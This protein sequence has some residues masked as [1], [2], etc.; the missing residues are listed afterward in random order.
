ML[1]SRRPRAGC[2]AWSS[3]GDGNT[4]SPGGLPRPGP[5]PPDALAVRVFYQ[6][7][8]PSPGVRCLEERL[9]SCEQSIRPASLWGRALFTRSP[10]AASAARPGA[11]AGGGSRGPPGLGVGSCWSGHRSMHLL[12]GGSLRLLSQLCGLPGMRA[13]GPLLHPPPHPREPTA[14]PPGWAPPPHVARAEAASQVWPQG[15][16]PSLTFEHAWRD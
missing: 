9:N 8:R 6:S 15:T 3:W 1:R 10:G 5:R 16:P 13:P 12:R 11:R 4:R 2:G 7:G 14:T